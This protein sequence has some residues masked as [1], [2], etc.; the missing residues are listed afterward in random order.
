MD[1]VR[2]SKQIGAGQR[3]AA[4]VV[5]VAIAISTGVGGV[6]SAAPAPPPAGCGLVT[7]TGN[8]FSLWDDVKGE[9]NIP[10]HKPGNLVVVRPGVQ[11][12]PQRTQYYAIRKGGDHPG[13]NDD[14][15]LVPTNRIQGIECSYLWQPTQSNLWR[16]A[17]VEANNWVATNPA[18]PI[19]LGVN[20]KTARGK[21]QLHI[22]LAQANP[23]TVA[24]L[25]AIK[26][27]A[28]SLQSWMG[29]NVE[30]RINDRNAKKQHTKPRKSAHYRVVK[31]TGSL[32]NLFT[33]LK[34]E[35]PA[36]EKMADQSIAVISAGAP[37]TYWLLNSNP[38][39]PGGGS[40]LA[41]YVY[42]WD[43]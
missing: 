26:N 38:T 21:D 27:P 39:L 16:Y 18:K 1:H 23:A 30:L 24:D 33:V 25:N 11:P 5:G 42:G 8:R 14:F 9:T 3:C 32:P 43:A 22:H 6:A 37:N 19:A 35:L 15:L 7:D 10:P 17:S 12:D 36:K 4:A 40:G 13:H 2:H 34:N 31:Y 29:T 20:S 28:T 41:D